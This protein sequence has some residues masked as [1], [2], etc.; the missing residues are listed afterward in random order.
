M[1]LHGANSSYVCVNTTTLIF[2]YWLFAICCQRLHASSPLLQNERRHEEFS[3]APKGINR[4]HRS[5][6]IAQYPGFVQGAPT[7]VPS[8]LFKYRLTPRAP[9]GGKPT[10]TPL[11]DLLGNHAARAFRE[12]LLPRQFPVFVALAKPDCDF[13]KAIIHERESAFNACRHRKA[14][15]LI[16]SVPQQICP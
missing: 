5:C 14:I 3:R 10:L 11:K 4:S 13:H 6:Q 2:S 8:V 16:D 1:P 15:T 9:R 12:P 7:Q